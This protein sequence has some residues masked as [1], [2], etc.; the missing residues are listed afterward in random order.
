MV[1]ITLPLPAN[2]KTPRN[3][4]IEELLTSIFA[5]EN[6]KLE[7]QYTKARMN[8][9]RMTK[10]LIN[11]EFIDLTWLPFTTERAQKLL[12]VEI[13]LYKGLHGTRLLVI[14]KDNLEK[15]EGISTLN[16]LGHL[17][18]VQHHSWSDYDVLVANELRIKGDL[19]YSGM[20][21]AVSSGLVD[22]F[23]RSA[24][25]IRDELKK[26]KD[27]QLIIEPTLVLKYPTYINFFVSKKAPELAKL[28]R[29]GMTKMIAD[30]SF[31]IIFNKYYGSNLD[32]LNLAKRQKIELKNNSIRLQV[33]N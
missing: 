17:V 22:Y 10:S 29:S 31:E 26:N 18:G 11:D 33:T 4:Y 15:F 25:A 3:Y 1:K 5:R 6:F 9:L 19:S 28:I 20:F 23:P 16:Q 7:L 8:Q 21:K 12:A 30:G 32:L 14:N 2:N 24:L 13:P 27:S